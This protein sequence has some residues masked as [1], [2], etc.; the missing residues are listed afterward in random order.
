MN[1]Y[2]QSLGANPL[3]ITGEH[4]RQDRENKPIIPGVP[5]SHKHLPLIAAGMGALV[6]TVVYVRRSKAKKRKRKK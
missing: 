6:L 3:S 5:I 1:Y 2:T 4:D